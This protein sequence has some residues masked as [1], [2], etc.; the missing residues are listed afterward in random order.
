GTIRRF[1]WHQIIQHWAAAAL[2]AVLA[3]SAALAGTAGVP[4][5]AVHVSAGIV[6][7]A[8]YLY[9]LFA[10]AAVGVRTDASPEDVAFL[11]MGWERKRLRRGPDPADPTG[12]YSP[13]EK[14]DYLAVLAWSLALAVTGIF[15]RWPG[16]LGVPGP[17]SYAWLRVGHAG[18]GAALSA[19]ILLV[20]VPRRWLRAPASFRRSIVG[21][22]VPLES[23]ETRP[24]WISD[25][26]AAGTLVPVPE[27][28]PQE[29][30]RESVQVRDLLEEGN[31]LAQRGLYGDASAAFEEALRLFPDYSQAR[32]NLAVARMKEGRTDLAAE[33][34]RLFIEMD[35]F[36]P[37]AGK[38]KD[39]LESVVRGKGEG[40]R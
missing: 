18:L 6:G 16:S 5:G 23:A 14:G 34:F 1:T 32:F 33:Q 7:A 17:G 15:L 30:H 25:L 9:H 3:V 26:V 10:L 36:N 13:E 4:W 40:G 29:G 39:L 22:A 27:E 8:F 37:M 38:A 2:W 12:K 24:G 11:P 19:H 21:G 20:H 31:R 35:P 28:V